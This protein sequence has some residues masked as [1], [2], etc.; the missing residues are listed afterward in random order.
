M[1]NLQVSSIMKVKYSFKLTKNGHLGRTRD[2]VGKN[3]NASY[4]VKSRPIR[5]V[6]LLLL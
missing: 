2:V 4:D 1:V 6:A 5:A 3:K